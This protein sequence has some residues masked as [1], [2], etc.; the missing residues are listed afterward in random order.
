MTWDCQAPG[1]THRQ[2]PGIQVCLGQLM[3]QC[4]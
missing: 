4:S 2:L 1:F 3:R